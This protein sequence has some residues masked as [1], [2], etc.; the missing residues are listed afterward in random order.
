LDPYLYPGTQTLEN[1][2]GLR[3]A[4]QLEAFERTTTGERLHELHERPLPGNFDVAHLKAIHRHI[5]QDVYLW[6]GEFRIVALGKAPIV[7]ELSQWFTP[8]ERLNQE[9]VRMTLCQNSLDTY[10]HFT[11]RRSY[12]GGIGLT[13]VFVR[14]S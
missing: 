4:Q 3:D 14:W 1:R 6:A 10:V 2:P 12:R 13:G 5:F 8:P 7:G 11:V 9:A